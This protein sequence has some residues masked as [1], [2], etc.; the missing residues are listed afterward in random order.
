MTTTKTAD[1]DGTLAQIYA[2]AN[3]GADIVRCT[4]NEAAAAEGL[5]QIVPRSPVPIVADIH[6]HVE[7]A[8]GRPGGRRP[9]AAPQPRQPAQGVGDQARRSRGQGPGG[10]HPHRRQRRLP[11]PGPLREVRRRHPRG[12]R[13][14]GPQRAGLLRR[15][16]LRRRQDLGQGVVGGPH[17]RRLPAGRRDVRPPAP[18]RRDRGR[19]AAGRPAEGHRRDRRAA[20]RGDRRHD[21]V[22]ADR[23]PG[24]RGPGRPPAAR[25]ARTARAQGPRPDRLPVLW[26]GRRST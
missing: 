20:G 15:G 3:A 7:M 1:V 13:R 18:P 25:V 5:A 26:A 4:C 24:R 12:P 11:P 2:L 19:A 6:F 21:P 10:A 16:R 14:V 22:L 23:R 9:G 17:D 8:L